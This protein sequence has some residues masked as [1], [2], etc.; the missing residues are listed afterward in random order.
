[1]DFKNLLGNRI[2]FFDG[3]M[4]TMLQ[5]AGLGPGQSPDVWNVTNPEAVIS[6]HSAYL[7]SGCNIVK[8]NTFGCNRYKL[9]DTGYAPGEV[10]SAAVENARKAIAALP[11]AEREN[12][13][14]AL[15]IGP[16]GKLLKPLGDLGFEEAVSLFADSVTAGAK[17]GAN[18][19]LIETMSDTYELKAAVLA[20]KENSD[21]PICATVTVDQKGKLLTGGDIPSIVALLEGLGVDALGFNCSLGPK[22]MLPFVGELI[23]LTSLPVILNPNAGLPREENGKTVFDVGPAEFASLMTEAAKAGTW[24][25]GGCCGT[26]PA[27]IRAL[28]DTCS[29]IPVPPVTKKR[30]TIASSYG[31][32]VFFG[33]GA[34]VL[35]GE[36]INPTGK[37]RLKQALRD[38]DYDYILQ[39][40]IRQQ[41]A[42]VQALDVN[43][44][45]PEIDEV[46]VLAD[47][48]EQIQGVCDLPLQ[49]DTA[50]EE[51]MAR[52]MRLYNGKPIVNSV[53]G[54]EQSMAAVFPLI[55]KYGGVIVALTLDENGIPETVE[56]RM[57]IAKRILARA[58]EYGIEK[59]AFL[60]DPL[61]MTISAGQDN[62][63]I[64][65]ECV[66]RFTKELGV[67]TS[68][69]VSNVS[70]GLP[71][72]DL[73]NANFFALAIGAGLNA[74]IMNP[75]ATGMMDAWRACAALLGQD[76][77]CSQFIAAYAGTQPQSA[78][79]SVA[80]GGMDL[81]QAVLKGLKQPAAL[82]AKAA[83]A[84]NDPLAVIEA[85]LI[86]ALNVAGERFEKGTLFL[87]QLLMC[88][89]AAK[90]AFEVIRA[91]M[92]ESATANCGTVVLATVHGDVHDIGKNIVRALLENYRFHV[93]DLGKD[94]PPQTV[95]DAVKSHQAGLV[96]LS[97]LMTTT[98]P[99]MARTIELMRQAHPECK[100]MVG[101]A[102][103]TKEYA[104]RIGADCFAKD[105]M[106]S[107]RYAQEVYGK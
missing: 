61:T 81:Y 85:G 34:P 64:T 102:V 36:R 15:D 104:K 84:S 105:A 51:A 99:S 83:L 13:F 2:L 50:D 35:I 26:T 72:R 6:I 76:V 70:F 31:K 73:I 53:N 46:A 37:A 56:G 7:A 16:T 107:V 48:M 68:L 39:E 69:G 90:A 18:L 30:L 63:L 89:D 33:S 1:M 94:V 98:V 38:H 65:L 93:I 41:E 17:A 66:R 4:G 20:V 103:L 5:E 74:A 52:A 91:S 54:K 32:A 55:E 92:G 10:A 47:I 23:S 12:R 59:E 88:A 101:G 79:V 95:V 22:E 71:R 60:F 8:T 29:A 44:G 27:H 96:G 75:F 78:Q 57:E 87:P 28:V 49:L 11:K 80:E 40:A 86:P 106:A 62:A 82:A 9:S 58:A 43:A 77:Q 42:G 19:A 3:A 25:L 67:C 100:I 45:L 24:L 14:V 97:A 21:L